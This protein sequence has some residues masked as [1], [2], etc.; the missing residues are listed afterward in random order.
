MRIFSRILLGLLL[1]VVV[2]AV[3][4]NLRAGSERRDE[5]D[6]HRSLAKTMLLETGKLMTDSLLAQE[7]TC[8]G[9]ER[10]PDLY[11]SNNPPNVQSYAMIMIDPDVPSPTF[12]LFNLTHWVVYNIPAE[13]HSLPEGMLIEQAVRHTAQFG[14]NS[15][16]DQKYI[17]PCPPVG[18]HAYVF[19]IYALDKR[20]T[21]PAPLDKAQLLDAMKGH[22]LAYGELKTY[23]AAD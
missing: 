11:W 4:M 17:G 7:C 14:R 9:G 2:V 20:L 15:M 1:I 10:T 22:I 5:A 6:Y 18:K 3:F 8:K 21:A 16:G 13:F 12:P 19:K 23:Y